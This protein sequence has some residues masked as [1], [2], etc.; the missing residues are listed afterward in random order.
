MRGDRRR[1]RRGGVKDLKDRELLERLRKVE[2]IPVKVY[3]QDGN[4]VCFEVQVG[5]AG[6]MVAVDKMKEKE[7]WS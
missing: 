2:S 3:G 5:V 7:E 4:P 1:V 6:A